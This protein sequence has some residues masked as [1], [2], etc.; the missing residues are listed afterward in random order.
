V[1]F[2]GLAG[3]P[4]RRGSPTP[5]D[6]RLNEDLNMNTNTQAAAVSDVLRKHGA[7]VG[8]REN[9]VQLQYADFVAEGIATAR[10][11]DAEHP[12]GQLF[13]EAETGSGKTIG[14]LVAAGLDCV[15]HGSRA[16]VATHTLALQRQII[17]YDDAGRITP[18]CDMGRALAII[19]AQTG[20]HLKAALRIGRR[21]FVDDVRAVVLIERLL[22]K[23]GLDDE[24][25]A[26]L[27]ALQ[28]WAKAN[29]GGEIRAFLE[30]NGLDALPAGIVQEDICI[31]ASTSKES[32]AYTAYAAHSK[33]THDA[34]IVVTNHAM[35]ARQ[36]LLVGMPIL[37]G[38]NE[39][40]DRPLGA[41]IVDECDRFA[42]AAASATS[43]ILPLGPFLS[44][45]HKWND[46]HGDGRG[47]KILAAGKALHEHMENMRRFVDGRDNEEVVVLWDDMPTVDQIITRGLIEDLGSS[48]TPLM[49]AAA[50]PDD[51]NEAVV[52]RYAMDLPNVYS[53]IK[54]MV[55]TGT[56]DVRRRGSPDVAALRWSPT[57]HF[58]ALRL[59]RL[60]PARVLKSIWSTWVQTKAEKEGD[61]IDPAQAQQDLYRAKSAPA[62]RTR[63]RAKALILTSATI[64][65]PTRHDKPDLVQMSDTFGV[66]G[67][68]NACDE[69]NQRGMIFTP[70]KFGSVDIVFSDPGAPSVY[71]QSNETDVDGERLREI[72]PKWVEYN[73][74]IA[75]AAHRMGGRVLVL[76]N[77][78]RATALLADA[79]RAASLPVI[80][81]T[82]EM[83]VQSCVRRLVDDPNGV[84]VTPGSWEGFDISRLI[85]PDGQ[86]AKIKHVVMTQL[87]FTRVDGAANTALVA[88]L[89]NH[90]LDRVAAE[91]VLYAYSS[92]DAMRKAKQ[93]FGRGIRGA[94]DSFTFWVGD[95]RFPRTST[96]QSMMRVN[97]NATTRTAFAN[98]VP[99]RFRINPLGPSAWEQGRVLTTAGKLLTSDDVLHAVAQA[100]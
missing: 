91:G 21:N 55:P 86:P 47:R 75:V 64:S 66:F 62:A 25:S 3:D 35:L 54:G 73:T 95:V 58:P 44:A 48:M 63:L 69:M 49:T 27:R 1:T 38:D 71:L 99:R 61:I 80:E 12:G 87:P 14:Y 57:R 94:A 15:A 33:A 28:Q 88:D 8:L 22:K 11:G 30:D 90:G 40:D 18:T 4:K 20:R 13:A 50:D 68:A 41:L 84:F 93:G 19:A 43:D 34:D 76:A 67:P 51:E 96:F 72:D 70:K 82:R 23:T 26:T 83:S 24:A 74:R 32:K 60:K 100:A 7:A 39:D 59:F 79:M 77:S 52:R 85:G 92:G 65:T 81:K 31:D 10:S 46:A 42:S 56:G 89:Q 45:V 36:A 53:A 29:P 37:E 16:I 97:P 9:P 78:Y 2:P 6:R 17:E 98:I 5:G